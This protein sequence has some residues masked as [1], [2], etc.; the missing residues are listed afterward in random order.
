MDQLDCTSLAGMY[1]VSTILFLF[2]MFSEH[3][4]EQAPSASWADRMEDLDASKITP[5]EHVVSCPD[6]F[7]PNGKI[8]W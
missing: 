7:S 1:E 3:G 8:V 4:E 2:L 5:G 6:Y